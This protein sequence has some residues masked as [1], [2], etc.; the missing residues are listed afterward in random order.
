MFGRVSETAQELARTLLFL[1]VPLYALYNYW[2]P[3]FPL[4]ERALLALLAV[5]AFFV[6]MQP[7]NRLGG[8]FQIAH[9]LLGFVV[10]GYVILNA[11]ELPYREGIPNSTDIMIGIAGVYLI[12]VAVK[13]C[14]GSGLATVTA[15]FLLY[16]FF[17]QH[18]PVWLGGHRGFSLERIISFLYLNDAGIMGF[19]HERLPQVHGTVSHSRKSASAGWRDGLCDGPVPCA[20]RNRAHRARP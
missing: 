8:A 20:V 5:S 19:R 12:L 13:A 11:H 18:L 1:A 14:L 3:G 7:R 4:L 16:L 6:S 2:Y 10:F 17:G 9:L 15:I